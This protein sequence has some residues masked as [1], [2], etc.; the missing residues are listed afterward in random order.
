M[1][2]I[3]FSRNL[4]VQKKKKKKKKNKKKKKT[5]TIDS[6]NYHSKRVIIFP[7]WV[8]V[9][10]SRDIPSELFSLSSKI[11]GNVFGEY[12]ASFKQKTFFCRHKEV[13]AL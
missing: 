6:T 8:Q 10:V 12:H 2:N 9:T 4:G 3:E 11:V 1:S 7:P 13:S 5:H